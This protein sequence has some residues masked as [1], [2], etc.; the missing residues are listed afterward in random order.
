MGGFSEQI[1][2]IGPAL[3][4]FTAM[5]IIPFISG[6]WYSMTDWNGI[7]SKM[8]FVG[9]KNYITLISDT[10]FMKALWFTLL[11]TAAV[12]VL[13]NLLAFVL[14]LLLTSAMKLRN[15]FRAVFFLPNVISGL[16]LGFIWQFI[17]VKVFAAIGDATHIGFF[18]L[19]WLGT[20]QTGFWAMVIVQLWQMAGYLMVIYIAGLTNVPVELIESSKI[21]G[22]NFLQV[23]RYIKIPMVMPSITIAFFLT[24]STAFK[25]FDLNYSLTNGNFDTRGLAYDIYSTAFTSSSYG[26]GSAKAFIFFILVAAVTI[27][28]TVYTKRKEIEA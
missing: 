24:T 20:T 1:T 17:F 15:V 9:L 18:Q 3:L 2:F 26:A 23:L 5:V 22:A 27:V 25:V 11:F 12:I 16:I 13:A 7:S 4:F 21:D 19:P 14:A 6:I 28:Q 10:Y 8:S